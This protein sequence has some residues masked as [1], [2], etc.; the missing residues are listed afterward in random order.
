MCLFALFMKKKLLCPRLGNASTAF[1]P[2]T[3]EAGANDLCDVEASLV[4]IGSSV[5]QPNL[6]SPSPWLT[7]CYDCLPAEWLTPASLLKTLAEKPGQV[8]ISPQAVPPLP[9]NQD[10]SKH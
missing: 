7:V 4:Y 6:S 5:I 10:L 3:Q 1:N 9:R 8:P 2:S